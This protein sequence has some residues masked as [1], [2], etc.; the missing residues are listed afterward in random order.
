M[1]NPKQD[2]MFLKMNLI[3]FEYIQSEYDSTNPFSFNYSSLIEETKI[4]IKELE[5][6]LEEPK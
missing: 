3:S 6:E 5:A 4:R 1:R 2:L